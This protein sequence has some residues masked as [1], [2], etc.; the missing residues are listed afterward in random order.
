MAITA[1]QL[2][3][4]INVEGDDVAKSKL[5]GV[6]SAVDDA[7]SKMSGGLLSGI[8]S[9]AGGFLDFAGK[10]G[11]G[12]MGFK[13]VADG[14]IG[15]GKALLAP[16]A[17][18]EQTTVGFETL[19]GKGKATQQMM[20]QLK[21]FAAATPFE[22]PELATDAQHMLAFGFSAKE[23][24][25]TLTDIG[26]AMSAMGKGS[27]DIDRVVAVFGQ[28]KAAGKAN[29][30]DMMQLADQGIPAWK[31]LAEAMHKTIP[32]VQDLSSKGLIPAKTAIDAMTSGMHQM[33]GGGMAAQAN[34][35]NGLL[36]TLKDN[37]GA[38][39][40]SFTGPL[41]DA[42]KNGLKVLGDSVS[43]KGF[44]DFA[45]GAGAAMATA[46]GNIGG[47]ID[48]VGKVLRTIPL[49]DFKA[50]WQ[51][52]SNEV[53][54]I[55]NK[56]REFM[57]SLN[58]LKGA[59]GDFD[60]L[61]EAIQK[62]AKSGLDTVSS[63]LWGISQALMAIDKGAGNGGIKQ[64]GDALIGLGKAALNTSMLVNTI[65]GIARHGKDLGEWWQQSV[66]PALR[67]AA[68]GF[69]NLGQALAS[70]L[71]AFEQIASSVHNNFQTAFDALLPVFKAAVPIIIQLAGGIANGLGAALKFLTPY[72]VAASQEIG[73]FA[74]QIA[75]RVAPMIMQFLT[76]TE[77]GIQ[78]F[79]Q[80]WTTIWSSIGPIVEG[81]WKEVVGIIQIAWAIVKGIILIGLDLMSGNWKQA[82]N[83][84]LDMFKGVWEGIKTYLSGAWSIIRGL[85]TTMV[86]VIKALWQ[87]LSDSL[88]GHSIVPDMIN[89]IVSWFAQLPGRAG[90]AVSNMVSG[91][92][93]WFGQ[94]AGRAGAA[95]QGMASTV[96]GAL[97]SLAGS[98]LSA[99]ANIV[100]QVAAG[101]R[102]AIGS[103]GSA[104][105]DVTAFIAAHLPHSPAK[106]GPLRDLPLMGAEI[107]KQIAQGMRIGT[108]SVAV[109][110]TQMV[111]PVFAPRFPSMPSATSTAARGSGQP[112]ILQINGQQFA[113]LIM[114]SVVS[115]IRSGVNVH[116]I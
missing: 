34:T 36:S 51:S 73:T 14:A 48:Y 78:F 102:S 30:G 107:A 97:N 2:T 70:L 94:L 7:G 32:E 47:A 27:A 22:F 101:I 57:S 16:N 91:V 1:S 109:A 49:G 46:F 71:P 53:G 33:F 79:Q 72:I 87:S 86:N 90:A 45:T 28:M 106:L 55:T 81:V 110:T 76:E 98:A 68:P 67:E 4:K 6:G 35:F 116:G 9:A 42:A 96:L 108:P 17:S 85:V 58:P 24:I 82:W 100:L 29:A 88:V 15:L 89:A 77:Q 11:M 112:I 83:D 38:A 26:D 103:V 43:S 95:V 20:D 60:P 64:A 31:F 56:F 62:I 113:R 115:Q 13:A 74:A 92:L 44:Q 21:A 59:V 40:R 75:T 25:P 54:S 41:F 69:R 5:Q 105:G 99:G 37:A 66:I 3:A 84:M 19:L 52:I 23:V 111:S 10:I 50:A 12:I 18:M 80:N 65:E 61:A 114:P 93:G 8:R 39:M 63:I 104:I